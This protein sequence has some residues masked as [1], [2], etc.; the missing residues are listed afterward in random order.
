MILHVND[1]VVP[2]WRAYIPSLQESQATGLQMSAHARG[3]AP[4]QENY[5]SLSPGRHST[6]YAQP[7]I[8]KR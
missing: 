2:N 5:I 6:I 3:S 4:T 1:F 8:K 7:I